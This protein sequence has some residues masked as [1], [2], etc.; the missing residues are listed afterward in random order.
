MEL[1]A[2][3]GKFIKVKVK[4]FDLKVIFKGLGRK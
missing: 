2:H 4:V 3:D 1:P